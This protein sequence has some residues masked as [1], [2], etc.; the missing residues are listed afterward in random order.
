MSQLSLSKIFSNWV[1]MHRRN[2]GLQ[3][4]APETQDREAEG[5]A[6]ALGPRIVAT[7]R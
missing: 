2:T 6:A 5:E 1:M 3:T 7:F 4:N